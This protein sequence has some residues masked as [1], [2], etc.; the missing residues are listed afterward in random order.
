MKLPWLAN[1][2]RDKP[3]L[4]A[5]FAFALYSALVSL[6]VQLLVLPFIVPGYHAGHGL[7][8]G[9]DTVGYH[10]IA[11][12]LAEGIERTGWSAWLLAPDGQPAAGLA[13]LFYVLLA[14]E[15]WSVIPVNATLQATGGIIV[16]QLLRQLGATYKIAAA[17]AALWVC[18]PSSLQ[19]VSQIQKDGYYF[20]GMLGVLLGW[21]LLL[22]WTRRESHPAKFILAIG[23]LATG[24]V[25]V[26]AARVYGLQIIQTL[27]VGLAIVAVPALVFCAWHGKTLP[28]RSAVVMAVLALTPVLVN[29]NQ[30]DSRTNAELPRGDRNF[31]FDGRTEYAI[32]PNDFVRKHWVRTDFLP[33][34]I[35]RTSMRMIVTRMGYV[36]EPYSSA[37][38]M[39]DLNVRILNATE[40]IAYLP[41]ALQIAFLAPF[42]SHWIAPGVTPGSNIMRKVAGLEMLLLYPMLLAGLPLA[43]WRWR[44]NYEF[45]L[46]TA[47][48]GS[49]LIAYTYATPNLGSLYRLRY[50]FL[51][52]FAAIGFAA[53]CLSI[54]E[55]RAR[56]SN[57]THLFIVPRI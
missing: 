16:L 48:C 46:I 45:W 31:T 17:S 22:R 4:T 56:R 27:A 25:L 18:F 21:T 5:W 40:F 23:I 54:C 49:I 33:A 2:A 14:P 44:R 9:G 55:F 30:L 38:S 24:V 47:F 32:K 53:L 6:P 35:D 11:S 34:A 13:A 10:A 36:G 26:G 8:A 51:M 39:I 57:L 50:G 15:P 43:A 41:R 1:A 19:W 12:L 3:L 42:P 52:T 28:A 7:L 29:P 37:G 20:A